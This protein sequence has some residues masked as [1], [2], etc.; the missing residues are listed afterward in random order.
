MAKGTP[1]Q[2]WELAVRWALAAGLTAEQ[3]IAAA[4]RREST[5]R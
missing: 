2:R 3:A 1:L 4:D 5:L